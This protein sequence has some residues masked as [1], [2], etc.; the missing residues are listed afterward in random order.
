MMHLLH[1]GTGLPLSIVYYG[2]LKDDMTMVR[3]PHQSY[4]EPI[5]HHRQDIIYYTNSTNLHRV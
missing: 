5:Y 4:T 1:T 2:H 3:P